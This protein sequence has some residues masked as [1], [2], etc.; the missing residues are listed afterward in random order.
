MIYEGISHPPAEIEYV[1]KDSEATVVICDKAHETTLKPIAEKLNIECITLNEATSNKEIKNKE[2]KIEEMD[3]NRG[4]MIVYTSGTTGRPK[5]VVTTHNNI[6]SQ[7]KTMITSWEW[8]NKDH[9]LHVLPLHHVHGIVNVL[10]C[11]LYI[12]A[13]CEIFPKFDSKLV[14]DRIIHGN[15]VTLF[16]AVPTIYCK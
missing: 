3:G 2:Y 12:G 10:L 14:W 5:G 11:P 15:D 4:A 1:L 7:I 8:S 16:M 9:I 6:E 13:T